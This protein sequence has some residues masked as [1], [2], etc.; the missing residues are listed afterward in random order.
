MSKDTF[1]AIAMRNLL[2][3]PP[4]RTALA[5]AGSKPACHGVLM[6]LEMCIAHIFCPPLNHKGRRGLG[7]LMAE[8]GDGTQGLPKNPP[9]Q[10]CPGPLEAAH[11]CTARGEQRRIPAPVVP[12]D[13]KDA[14]VPWK[15]RISVRHAGSSG[16][17]RCLWFCQIKENSRRDADVTRLQS[18]TP[19]SIG[20]LDSA[21]R[22]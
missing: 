12:P 8:T 11:L 5:G 20:L 3:C 10:G 2:F 22:Q 1:S 21:D 13:Q 6:L 18:A 4:L 16:V 14:L 19:R 9:F 7:V 15:R 17:S